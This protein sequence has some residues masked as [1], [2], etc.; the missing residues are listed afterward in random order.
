MSA[1]DT[2]DRTSGTAVRLLAAVAVLVGGLVH[3]QLYF[4]GYRSLPDANLGRSFLL[5]GAASVAVSLA[6]RGGPGVVVWAIMS[7]TK[8]E[9]WSIDS[10][11]SGLMTD[12]RSSIPSAR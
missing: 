5:N 8:P 4:R 12:T 1:A 9:S 3:F 2:P 10:L 11:K 7:R 6:L